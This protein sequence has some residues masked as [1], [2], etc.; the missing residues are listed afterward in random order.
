[1]PFSFSSVD[2]CKYM[3]AFE[4]LEVKGLPSFS[5]DQGRRV[6]MANSHQSISAGW[7]VGAPGNDREVGAR[8][9]ANRSVDMS[10]IP[11]LSDAAKGGCFV[12]QPFHFPDQHR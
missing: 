4:L 3:I 1:M 12:G 10:P 11:V 8:E 7:L 9:Y 6:S 2:Q 5:K